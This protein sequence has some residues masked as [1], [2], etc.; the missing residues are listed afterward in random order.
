MDLVI[1]HEQTFWRWFGNIGTSTR[2]TAYSDRLW[3]RFWLRTPVEVI[4]ETIFT[5]CCKRLCWLP[6]G[7]NVVVNF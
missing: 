4:R 1:N 2:S 3:I 6:E 5:A 7:D